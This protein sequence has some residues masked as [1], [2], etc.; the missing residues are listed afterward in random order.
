MPKAQVAFDPLATGLGP[1]LL[2][3]AFLLRF[4]LEGS[5]FSECSKT[6]ISHS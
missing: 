5:M 6:P 4:L 2:L 3:L 1:A